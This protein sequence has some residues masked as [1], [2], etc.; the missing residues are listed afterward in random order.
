MEATIEVTGLHKRFGPT[1]ALDGAAVALASGREDRLRVSDARCEAL[2]AS[3]LQ[4][5]HAPSAETVAEAITCTMR[6][7]GL[8]GCV[9]RMAQEFGDHPEAAAERMR[10][11]RRVVA[12]ARPRGPAANLADG[13]IAI[14]TAERREAGD[15]RDV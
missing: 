11:V 9:S 7:F 6:Q 1:T 5:S 12:G 14:G 8:R 2:F 15:A 4:P 10:W 3:W 13:S